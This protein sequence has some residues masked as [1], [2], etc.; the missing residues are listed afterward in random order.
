[1]H[2]KILLVL[3]VSAMTGIAYAKTAPLVITYDHATLSQSVGG[4]AERAVGDPVEL[5]VINTNLDCFDYN[6]SP[7]MLPPASAGLTAPKTE[8]SISLVQQRRSSG[9][10]MKVTKKKN[11]PATC[12]G[13]ALVEHEWTTD[14]ETLGWEV[15][16]SGAFAFDGLRDRAYFLEDA[17]VGGVDGFIVNRDRDS[18]SQTNQRPAVMI[19]LYNSGWKGKRGIS[20]APITFGFSVDDN[21]RYML[22]TSA[23]FGEKLYVTAGGV[24]GKVKVLPVGL[25]EGGFTTE[26]NAIST[27]GTKSEVSWFLSLSYSMFGTGAKDQFAGVFGKTAPQP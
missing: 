4:I 27:L 10:T 11:Q 3:A 24:V 6:G 21:S 8:F 5:R 14:V 18:E 20:W 26:Q 9:Y 17:N 2:R 23:K 1:M 22:G 7:K 25:V 16:F 13:V 15:A 12:T 19:H